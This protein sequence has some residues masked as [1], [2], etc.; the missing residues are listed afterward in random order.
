MPEKGSRWFLPQALSLGWA[1]PTLTEHGTGWFATFRRPGADPSILIFHI[2]GDHDKEETTFTKQQFA[3]FEATWEK[4][5]AG[6]ASSASTSDKLPAGWTVERR[7]SRSVYVAPDGSKTKTITAAWEKHAA[8]GDPK[9]PPATEAPPSRKRLVR[10]PE[11][12]DDKVGKKIRVYLAD[13]PEPFSA[14]VVSMKP[15]LDSKGNACNG[16]T[17]QYDIDGKRYHDVE[18][19]KPPTDPNGLEWEF[20]GVASVLVQYNEDEI[21]LPR[22]GA[23]PPQHAFLTSPP[24][25][26]PLQSRQPQFSKAAGKRPQETS[27]CGRRIRT[28]AWAASTKQPSAGEWTPHTPVSQCVE[29]AIEAVLAR[30]RDECAAAADDLPEVRELRAVEWFAGSAR[31]SFA[32]AAQGFDV[33]I[34]DRDPDVVEW[35]AHGMQPDPTHLWSDEFLDIDEGVLYAQAPYDYMHFGVECRSFTGLG[36]AGQ[37]RSADNDFLGSCLS[38]QQGNQLLY[39]T[40]DVIAAQLKRNPHFLFTIENPW[41]G[42][43]KHHMAVN[44][45]LEVSRKNG[46]LGATRCVLDYCRFWD[47]KGE[48]PFHKRTIFWTNSPTLIREFGEHK[49]PAGLTSHFLCERGSRPCQWAATEK[50]HRVVNSQTARDAT[51]YPSLL[52]SRIAQGIALDL[53]PQRWRPL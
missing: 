38:S 31:L 40:I 5:A 36:H 42:R 47:G 19:D 39:K 14:L 35:S 21:D 3:A 41:T 1:N 20:A 10:L 2:D 11:F 18:L 28:S 32:L 51:P 45:R 48:R 7:G 15:I 24:P 44:G 23:P 53:S 46:G 26:A 8:G 43:M 13:R 12:E 4:H 30:A 52:V 6:G 37:G 49:P 17:I 34:H 50:G 27:L 22:K 9:P 33:M 16:Y 29:D 25:T